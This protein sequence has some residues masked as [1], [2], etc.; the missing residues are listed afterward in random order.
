MDASAVTLLTGSV[1]E[2]DAAITAMGTAP[3]NY[4]SILSAGIEAATDIT[5]LAHWLKESQS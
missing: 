5:T 2:I 1:A 3:T 4:N